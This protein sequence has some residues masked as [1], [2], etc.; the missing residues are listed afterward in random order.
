[1]DNFHFIDIKPT[2]DRAETETIKDAIFKRALEKSN[3]L[4]AAKEEAY[5]V[6]LQND[7]MET[8]R[9][10]FQNTSINPFNRFIEAD[11]C[12]AGALAHPREAGALAHSRGSET[13][14]D[15]TISA[16]ENIDIEEVYAGVIKKNIESVNNS[17]FVNSVKEETMRAARKE[18]SQGTNL[19]ATLNF[20]NTQAAI[21]M[22]EDAHSKINY[23]I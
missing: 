4:A 12:E 3:A 5:A 16:N 6:Q 17:A 22:A 2:I 9:E 11:N 15:N 8:A 10:S 20:L 1:M 19:T 21:R 13:N 14:T 7:I 18:F 23:L